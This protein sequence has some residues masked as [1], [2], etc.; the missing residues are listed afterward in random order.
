[1]SMTGYKPIKDA[2]VTILGA[3]SGV[4]VVYGKEPK[5]VGNFPAIA[6]SAKSDAESY[7]SIGPGGTNEVQYQH[8]VRVYFRTDEQNDPDYEDICTTIVDSVKQTLRANITL[9]GSC[10]YSIPVAGQ[11]AYGEKESPVRIYELTV[12]STVYL[13]RDTS[14]V[15]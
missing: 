7:R 12:N 10:N 2:L 3:V 13:K 15:V 5:A 6:V 9:N 14:T 8:F 1:M 11:W 4:Q